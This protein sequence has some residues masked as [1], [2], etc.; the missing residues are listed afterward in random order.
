[1]SI[2]HSR[3]RK[4]KQHVAGR[5]TRCFV[6]LR[7]MCRP[8]VDTGTRYASVRLGGVLINIRRPT[9]ARRCIH[10]HYTVRTIFM[11]WEKKVSHQICTCFYLY[12][13]MFCHTV[14]ISHGQRLMFNILLYH[15]CTISFAYHLID[16]PHLKQII[17]TAHQRKSWHRTYVY[18]F[19]L[20]RHLVLFCSNIRMWTRVKKTTRVFRICRQRWKICIAQL[21]KISHLYTLSL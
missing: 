16:A 21:C 8:F 13:V 1:M 9:H 19:I 11:S 18:N 6:K 2:I 7:Y 12:L 3:T 15:T 4:R 20:D 14:D 17:K 10:R 5:G